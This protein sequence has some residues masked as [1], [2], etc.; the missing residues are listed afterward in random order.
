MAV[1]PAGDPETAPRTPENSARD[2]GEAALPPVRRG[3]SARLQNQTTTIPTVEFPSLEDGK[4]RIT[5][6]VV[7]NL[8]SNLKDIIQHQS[9]IIELTRQEIKEIRNEQQMLR[10]Q[11]LNLLKEQ[12]KRLP[13]STAR[14]AEDPDNGNHKTFT[15]NL[16]T[17][18][19]NMHIRS[20]LSHA[21]ATKDTKV[22]GIGTTKT[23]YV[24]R[25]RDEQSATTARNNPEWLEGL[26]NDTKLVKPR[27]GVVVHRVP[28]EDFELDEDKKGGIEK[29]MRE[30]GLAEAGYQVEDITW[31]KRKDMPL[32]RSAL[33][34]I[35][36]N[37]L[38]AANSILNNGLL[39]G[40]RYI[41]SMESY[42]VERKRCRRCQ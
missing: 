18:V 37:T 42:W 15:R 34:G 14:P 10:D 11:N 25:F 17:N 12:P 19:A 33:M 41:R 3:R 5:T 21:E 27:Y 8:I 4:T 36:L 9:K 29:I 26:G 39:V 6:Q 20:A 16:P 7:G 13:E 22:A 23:G 35:W 24:I 32:G 1:P 28:T 31:L 30:N 40:Q 38:E 2:G